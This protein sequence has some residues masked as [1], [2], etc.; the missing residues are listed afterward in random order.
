MSDLGGI[1]TGFYIITSLGKPSILTQFRIATG[2]DHPDRDPLVVSIEGS[3]GGNLTE[4]A[5]WTLIYNGSTGLET[6]P[7]RG[8]FGTLQLVPNTKAFTCYRLLTLVKRSIENDV[9]YSEVE[10]YGYSINLS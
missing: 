8:I 7:G 3:N 10:F 5:S 2:N 9:Q 4:G 6:N 1:G